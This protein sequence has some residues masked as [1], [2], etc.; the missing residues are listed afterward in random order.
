MLIAFNT[1]LVAGKTFA[2]AAAV[3]LLGKR[4]YKKYN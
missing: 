4:V 2:I 1:R 3:K